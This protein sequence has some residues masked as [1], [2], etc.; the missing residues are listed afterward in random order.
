MPLD[1]ANLRT[2]VVAARLGSLSRAAETL[3]ITQ[4]ALSR[5]VAEVEAALGL[6]LFERLPRGVRPTLE[7]HA[8]ISHA[9]AALRSIEEGR[10]AAHEVGSQRTRTIAFGVLEN[11]CDDTLIAICRDAEASSSNAVIDFRPRA[12]SKEVTSDLLS[13][14]TL[15]A[16]RYDRESD[17]Q[18]QSTWV[19]DDPIAIVCAASHPLAAK[20][21]A[22]MDELEC[23][24][25]IGNSA[26]LANAAVPPSEDLPMAV[27]AGWTAMRMV[28]MYARLKLVEAGFGLAMIRRA[29]I[30]KEVERGSIVELVTPVT[31]AIPMFLIWRRGANLGKTGEF[32]KEAICA[33]L[34]DGR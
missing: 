21:S 3:N 22:T 28:P 6:S 27:Y 4:P 24:Q 19:G 9:E 16:L 33:R 34:A 20:G 23:A 8:F 10:N 15:L 17:P 31:L 7:G 2:I 5:R 26:R 18:I 11:L 14:A 29:S 25:W 13:G 12:L 1:L 30:R 32:L